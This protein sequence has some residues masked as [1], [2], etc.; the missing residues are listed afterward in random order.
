MQLV[1]GHT[2]SN[3]CMPMTPAIARALPI[4]P[5]TCHHAMPAMC[6]IECYAALGDARGTTGDDVV[7]ARA[8]VVCMTTRAAAVC[9]AVVGGCDVGTEAAPLTASHHVGVSADTVSV[10]GVG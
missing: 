4:T 2:R 9:S 8:P 6:A 5:H 7:A 3:V 1:V 10:G